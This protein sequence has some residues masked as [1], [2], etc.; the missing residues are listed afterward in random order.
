MVSTSFF[1][2]ARSTGR[3]VRVVLAHPGDGLLDLLVGDRRRLDG[4]AGRG[5]VA[6]RDVR[7]DRHGGRVLERLA[8]L[9]LA[10]FDVRPVEP[11]DV[12]EIRDLLERLVDDVGRRVLP[13]VVRA[14]RA[15]VEGARRLARPEARDLGVLDVLRER[16]VARALEPA[17]VD[18]DVHRHDRAGLALDG[19][20]E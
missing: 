4:H 3:R 15:L 17:G 6:E 5:R 8:G 7:A 10:H 16:A 11:V 19:V 12:L 14:V 18:L 20:G 13:E 2:A 1:S 9:E